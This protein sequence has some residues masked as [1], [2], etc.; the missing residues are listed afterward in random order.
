MLDNNKL[1]VALFCTALVLG[2]ALVLV[3]TA[4]KPAP[5]Y[6]GSMVQQGGDYTMT[7][8]RLTEAQEM[9]WLLDARSGMIGLYQYDLQSKALELRATIGVEDVRAAVR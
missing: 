4:G 9:V 5:A 2:T 6:G 3:S 8:S 7:V 1:I